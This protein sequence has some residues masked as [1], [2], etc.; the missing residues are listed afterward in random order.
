MD[1]NDNQ[2]DDF[3]GLDADSKS[4][5]KESFKETLLAKLTL[6]TK[7][8]L[9]PK[10]LS[11]RERYTIFALALIIVGSL[12]AMPIS[13]YY[14]YTATEPDYGGT[15]REGILG[16]PHLINPL[17]AQVN[18]ADRDLTA[19]VYS[20][21][22][23]YNSD[24]KLVPDLA[25]SYEI[26]ADGLSYTVY[27]KENALWQDGP[28]VTA[29]DVIFTI[30]TA[31]NPDYG[32][33]LRVNWQGVEVEKVND[34]AVLFRLKNKYAQFVNN[35]TIGILPQHLWQD[36]KP[37]NFTLSD[38]N[39]KPIGSGPYQFEKLKKNTNGNI[40]S[41]TFQAHRQ[42]YDGRPYI[43]H[44]EIKFYGS[45]EQLIEAYNQSSIDN[46]GFISAQNLN[47]LKFQKRLAINQVKL[48]RYFAT[49][50]NQNQSTVLA[51]KNV[52]LA[53]A[54]A[55]DK[56]A[57]ID[58][59]L[60]GNGVLVNSPMIGGILDIN[61][62]V[63]VYDHDVDYAK[64]VLSESGWVSPD[65][66]GVLSKNKDR[67]A[68]KIT[69]STWPEL[70]EVANILQ[71]QWSAIGVEVTIESLP[72]SQLQ[73]VIKERQ[74]QLLL[75]GEILTIDPDPFSLWHSS[76]KRDPGLNLAL[77][78]N[79]TADTLLEDAR[80]TL[81]PNDRFKKY[82]DFQKVVIEDI[83]ALFLYSPYYLYAQTKDLSDASVRIISMPSDRFANIS[84]WYLETQ[85]SWK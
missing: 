54:H 78:D 60:D 82:D 4:N 20:G 83:P 26:A 74:Y 55:T 22:M 46:I 68:I 1:K 25:K 61:P 10:V 52:R 38:L 16:A 79:K 63:R 43:D 17:L 47:Q 9:V 77:Y 37:I 44:L 84:K 35:L 24:G 73:Q 3:F 70:T 13:A 50:F 23:K 45:E 8:R 71:E 48:P 31:Q 85:R 18:D 53:L 58:R 81:N 41:Y 21:L 75:F 2:L 49:F 42:H 34:F 27:L 39:T 19:L 14:H 62:D 72:I 51:D 30:Q 66:Q 64:R 29:D 69:T 15:L 33:I 5:H 6:R 11:I 76:Q 36:I 12:I 56:Q 32:S 7:L 65:D 59:I 67:L 57:L 80:Q 28:R 40:E